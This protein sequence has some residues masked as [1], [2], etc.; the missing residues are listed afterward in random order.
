M[1]LTGPPHQR[2]TLSPEQWQEAIRRVT[3][4]NEGV[5][6][7]AKWLG[8]NEHTLRNNLREEGYRCQHGGNWRANR[9]VKTG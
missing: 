4:E 1:N 9:W 2:T 8:W 3:V 6:H 7:V 5:L